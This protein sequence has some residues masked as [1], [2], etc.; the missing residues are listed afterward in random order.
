MAELAIEATFIQHLS[1]LTWDSVVI[2]SSVRKVML[3]HASCE[4]KT[5]QGKENDEDGRDSP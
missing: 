3:C 4:Q 5:Q 1:S 2:P